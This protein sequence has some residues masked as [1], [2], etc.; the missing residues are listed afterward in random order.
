MKKLIVT[1]LFCIF[2]WILASVFD[3]QVKEQEQNK[4]INL[5]YIKQ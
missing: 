3:Q 5:T 2:A 1:M 4:E